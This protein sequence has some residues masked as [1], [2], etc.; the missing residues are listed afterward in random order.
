MLILYNS[1]GYKYGRYREE[2]LGKHIFTHFQ[3]PI[4]WK[5]T[6]SFF[7]SLFLLANN[8]IV[9]HDID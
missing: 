3:K 8:C 5:K 4:L 2:L 9:S 6:F 1:S 7:L